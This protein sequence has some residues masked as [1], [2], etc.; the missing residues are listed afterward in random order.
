LEIEEL[1][2]TPES[3][4]GDRSP[5]KYQR[6]DDK[7]RRARSRSTRPK[8]LSKP[9]STG[10]VANKILSFRAKDKSQSDI[11]HH[12]ELINSECLSSIIKEDEMMDVVRSL[13]ELGIHSAMDAM[14]KRT[15]IEDFDGPRDIG[16]F[17]I[18][19]SEASW[20]LRKKIVNDSHEDDKG[21]SWVPGFSKRAESPVSKRRGKARRRHSSSISAKRSRSRRKNSDIVRM[22]KVMKGEALSDD[23]EEKRRNI[24]ALQSVLSKRKLEFIHSNYLPEASE[25]VKLSEAASKARKHS[26]TGRRL[27]ISPYPLDDKRWY[28]TYIGQRLSTAERKEMITDREKRVS[29][30]TG[31]LIQSTMSYFMAH[32]VAD[33]IP[34]E[35]ALQ[36]TAIVIELAT[37]YSRDKAYH[38]SK[39]LTEYIKHEIQSNVEMDVASFITERQD[40][41]L[42]QAERNSN[43]YRKGKGNGK[44]KYDGK[45]YPK[46]GRGQESYERRKYQG[47]GYQGGDRGQGGYQGEDRSQGGERTQ[48]PP[49]NKKDE[50]HIC[51]DH[52]PRNGKFCKNRNCDKQHINTRKPQDAEKFDK[53]RN[54]DDNWKEK[55]GRR[56]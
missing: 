10:G 16:H 18:D 8:R 31:E 24:T 27:Y 22:A 9:T 20:N 56:W 47:Q 43:Q 50:S 38:Y 15:A 30:P 26:E 19:I 51:L 21:L 34:A 54:I 17:M 4:S 29:G 40:K 55:T 39:R 25:V 12:F 41:I 14:T 28:P 46:G 33:V 35:A 52:D 53:A 45:D 3:R 32:V 1:P 13:G 44:G 48:R 7:G 42:S 5:K 36:A 37:E 23:E 6:G 49:T 11:V 2:R